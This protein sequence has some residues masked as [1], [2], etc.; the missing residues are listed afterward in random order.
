MLNSGVFVYTF[1]SLFCKTLIFNVY[2]GERGI[3][4]PGTLQ[5]GGFQDRCNRSLCHLS[6]ESFFLL[7]R[8]KDSDFCEIDKRILLLFIICYFQFKINSKRYMEISKLIVID[9]ILPFLD[10]PPHFF[11]CELKCCL[12]R[13]YRIFR[14]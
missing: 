8:C 10:N 3:Q 4:T 6:R 1:V 11:Q 9:F 7:R 12:H 5:Y 13:L 14:L 2:C